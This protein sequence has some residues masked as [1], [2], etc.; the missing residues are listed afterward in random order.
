MTG[1][2]RSALNS[3]K[4]CMAEG[5]CISKACGRAYEQS[6]AAFPFSIDYHKSTS[7]EATTFDFQARCCRVHSL[8][9][10]AQGWHAHAPPQQ[11]WAHAL[12]CDLAVG[13]LR[14][15]HWLRAGVRE[16]LRGGVAALR[17]AGGVGAAP[18]HGA[19]LQ[20]RCIPAGRAARSCSGGSVHFIIRLPV[21]GEHVICMHV[22]PG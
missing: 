15:Q 3:A 17:G 21:A 2:K 6:A 5:L 8:A 19:G 14:H 1:N 20:Q 9:A 4:T 16:A 12:A 22:D 18:G 7:S 11:C 13:L 10:A